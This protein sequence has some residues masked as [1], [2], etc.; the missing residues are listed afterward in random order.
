ME[1]QLKENGELALQIPGR[2]GHR[3]HTV[4]I[5]TTPEG[6]RVI[7]QILTADR[8]ERAA[9]REP[10]FATEAAPTQQMVQAYLKHHAQKV[11]VKVI[12]KKMQLVELDI[13]TLELDF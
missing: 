3:G 2:E 4:T 1:I 9:N 10:R 13:S 7:L 11:P 8:R 6:L 12:A 5:P